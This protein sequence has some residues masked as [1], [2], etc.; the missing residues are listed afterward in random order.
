M[1]ALEREARAARRVRGGEILCLACA[2]VAL[3][4]Y[5]LLCI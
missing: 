4:S 5:A 2:L 3:A 1:T